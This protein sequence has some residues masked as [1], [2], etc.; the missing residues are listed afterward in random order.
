MI[1]KKNEYFVKKEEIE[2]YEYKDYVLA[3]LAKFCSDPV[4][5]VGKKYKAH[6]LRK[7]C[8]FIPNFFLI[9]FIVYVLIFTACLTYCNPAILFITFIILHK[10]YSSLKIMRFVLKEKMK[11]REIKKKLEMEN[12]SDFC[13]SKK[14][15]WILGQSGYWMELVKNV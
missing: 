11:M 12:N 13:T 2:F 6:G 15:N 1:L 4:F 14:I 5:G 10:T 7:F 9:I 3:T 8:L